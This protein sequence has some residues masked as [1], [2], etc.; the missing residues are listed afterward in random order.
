MAIGASGDWVRKRVPGTNFELFDD[1]NYY[2]ALGN[3]YTYIKPLDITLL[4]QYGRFLGGDVGWRFEARHGYR[5]LVQFYG[6]G[7]ISYSSKQGIQR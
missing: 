5:R 7:C 3:L 4:S 2:T 1:Q 6:Y